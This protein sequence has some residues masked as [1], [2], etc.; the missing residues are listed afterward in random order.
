[1]KEIFAIGE[2]VDNAIEKIEFAQLR[3]LS[4]GNLPE[5]TSFCREVKT[6]SA[7]PNRQVSQEESTTMYCS[8]EITL[9]ISTLLFNEK[10]RRLTFSLMYNTF[11]SIMRSLLML[12][13]ENN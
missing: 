2:E 3:S 1:M 10:V 7:S 9:G 11:Y 4:L 8:S 5:V 6:P 12:Y 13:V